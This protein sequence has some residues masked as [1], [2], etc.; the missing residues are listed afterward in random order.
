MAS[1]ARARAILH[2]GMEKTGT[3]TLQ[4]TLYDNRGRLEQAGFV[5]SGAAGGTNHMLLANYALGDEDFGGLRL[6]AG[7]A[8]AD[9]LAHF[10]SRLESG[11]AAEIAEHPDKTFLFSNEHCQSQLAREDDIRRLRDLLARFFD[12]IEVML[13]LRRQDRVAVSRYSTRLK[14]GYVPDGILSAASGPSG[15][16]DYLSL[17]ERWAA[18]FPAD[19]LHIGI[20]GPGEPAGASI[21][22]DFRRRFGLPA[23]AEDQERKN[24]ELDALYQEFLGLMNAKLGGEETPPARFGRER[25]QRIVADIGAGSGK[26]P[27]RAQAE[28]FYA[29]FREGN[30]ELRRRYLSERESLFDE[31]FSAYPEQADDAVL[32][33]D[34][35]LDISADLW[36]RIAQ[37]NY[38]LSSALYR[39]K[40]HLHLL[41][42]RLKLARR[43]LQMA[44][45]RVP[46]DAQG[47]YLL[48]K[49]HLKAGD[50]DE[51]LHCARK[52]LAL[53]P[54]A[55][56]YGR[57]V[58]RLAGEDDV[59]EQTDS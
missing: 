23:L 34:K 58:E 50:R 25:L 5:Y 30:E 16:Y 15:F 43:Q 24:V 54:K 37:D 29:Q 2:I 49:T 42:G 19:R 41:Q 12:P 57:M 6:R 1:Q 59:V 17:V 21:V 28:Q 26:R 56:P 39:D 38:R 53:R 4:A 31:D 13:Y 36:Q 46:D 33:L 55:K 20:H 35:A 3:T 8:D 44:V 10:R 51:A 45:K 52:A 9:D 22:E 7:I 14:A 11:L 32:D 48:A 27:S 40:G 18:V 47:W